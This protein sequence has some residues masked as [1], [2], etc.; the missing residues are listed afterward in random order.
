MLPVAGM[1]HCKGDAHSNA[2][3]DNCMVCLP[4]WEIVPVCV[5]GHKLHET[6]MFKGFCQTCRKFYTIDWTQCAT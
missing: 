5:L 6:N 3:I 1:V 2:N 4:Y